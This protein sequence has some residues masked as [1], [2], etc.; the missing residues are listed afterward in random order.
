MGLIGA[1]S[2][3]L[4]VILP[5]YI[6]YRI[7][8]A[9][10]GTYPDGVGSC[11]K[12]IW[13][14]AGIIT[15]GWF[16]PFA[17]MVLW[18]TRNQTDRSFL[19]GLFATGLSFIYLPAIFVVAI[20]SSRR[21]GR[22][23]SKVLAKGRVGIDIFPKP[24]WEYRS[25]ASLFG[26]PL[27]HIRIGDPFA[28]VKKPVT[29]WVAVGNSAIGGLFAFGAMAI[30]P[31]SIGGLAF[32]FLSFGG[33]SIGIFAL[34]AIALGVWPLFGGL[35]VG[36]QAFGGC[37]AI[38]W[39]AAVG[40]FALAHDLA[41]GRIACAA[42]ANNGIA[43]KILEPNLA[44]RCAQFIGNHWLWINLLWV[45]PFSIQGLII[46]RARRRQQQGESLNP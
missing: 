15:L 3:P 34:G 21:Y 37:F 20:V 25:K 43:R 32:G 38:G 6:G 4:A 1:L 19:P 22:D 16:L 41:L 31:L 28:F 13:R 24:A 27:I 2:G 45:V 17:A 18:V 8:I 23:L 14:K 30:A 29:A 44:W 10:A 11:L 40:D 42:Q 26:L 5:N 39:N 35:I 33:L 7:A 36:W 12:A 46:A 9:S